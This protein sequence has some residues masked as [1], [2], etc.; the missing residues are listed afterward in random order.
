MLYVLIGVAVIGL[1]AESSGGV[2]HNCGMFYLMR[3]S[4]TFL[5][6][7]TRCFTQ[8]E[9]WQGAIFKTLVSLFTQFNYAEADL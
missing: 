4:L 2:P 1:D 8:Y 6:H 3:D 5:L 9:L 7:V